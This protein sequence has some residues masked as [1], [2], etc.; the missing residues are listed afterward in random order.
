MEPRLPLELAHPPTAWE[1]ARLTGFPV[2]VMLLSGDILTTT[3]VVIECI[4][5]GIKWDLL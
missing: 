3:H 2:W 1:C 5:S 4:D